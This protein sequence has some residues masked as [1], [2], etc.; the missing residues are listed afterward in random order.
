MYAAPMI[1]RNHRLTGKTR[2]RGIVLRTGSIFDREIQ[3]YVVLQVEEEFEECTPNSD[4]GT[5]RK[6]WRDARINECLKQP[7]ELPVP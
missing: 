2:Y 1:D 7:S 6:R 3:E 4:S 5:S